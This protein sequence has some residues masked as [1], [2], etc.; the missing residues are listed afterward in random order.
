MR[1]CTPR[2]GAHVFELLGI[3]SRGA[4]E[5]LRRFN[6]VSGIA[7]LD[8]LLDEVRGYRD[9]QDRMDAPGPASRSTG[10][11]RA[12]DIRSATHTQARDEGSR[13]RA[14]VRGA[15][16]G[17]D[18]RL[19]GVIGDVKTMQ[20]VVAAM[21]TVDSVLPD[22]DGVKLTSFAGRGLLVPPPGLGING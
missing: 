7:A 20:D 16:P 21:R 17:A 18:L 4:A 6:E 12:R 10:D 15:N 5:L 19:A 14:H 9:H 2:A 13:P 3:A 22:D 11:G 1:G 8:D